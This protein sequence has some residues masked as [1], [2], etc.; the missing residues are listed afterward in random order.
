MKLIWIDRIDRWCRYFLRHVYTEWGLTID[1][2]DLTEGRQK[3]AEKPKEDHA[4][5][6]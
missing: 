5:R 4:E 6:K 2:I 1:Q 3:R